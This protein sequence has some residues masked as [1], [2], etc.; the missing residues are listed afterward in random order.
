MSELVEYLHDADFSLT[1]KL[2]ALNGDV[3]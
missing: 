1:D 2:V 3:I